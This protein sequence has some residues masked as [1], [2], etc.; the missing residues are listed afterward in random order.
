MRLVTRG[1]AL[2]CAVAPSLLA[3]QGAQP[4]QSNVL[5][6]YREVVKAG[7][8]P[9]HNALETAWSW[10][11]IQA[12]APSGFIAASVIS[13][14]NE[15]WYIAAF[16]TWAEFEKLTDAGRSPTL[17]AID[18]RFRS[19][20]DEFLSDARGMTLR[21]RTELSYGGPADL[22]NMR[23]LSATRISVR[24]GHTA[25]YEEARKMVKAA[26]EAAKLTDK[27]SVWE[28]TSGAP[29]GTFYQFVARK[30]LAE[31]DS[32]ATIH[33]PAYTAALGGEEGQKK[34][35]TLTANAVINSETD[36]LEFTPS[37]SVPPAGWVEANPKMWKRS[38]PAAAA[39]KKP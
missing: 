30:T 32:G 28:V 23:Y 27:Y 9:A 24:P 6:I 25:E 13:G 2:L 5:Q 34:L 7:K 19:Q 37:Q 18:K 29:A 26:H 38:A 4:P 3:A 12:K 31:L 14:P 11:M 33:G 22:P 35:A 15:M 1:V 10:A 20:E 17:S 16:P 8:A 36:V 21:P 39:P